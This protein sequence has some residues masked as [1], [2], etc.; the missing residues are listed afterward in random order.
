[1][2]PTGY[3]RW[4]EKTDHMLRA[5]R[6]NEFANLFVRLQVTMSGGGFAICLDAERLVWL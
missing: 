6:D 3:Q 5:Q 4:I 2:T 1:M